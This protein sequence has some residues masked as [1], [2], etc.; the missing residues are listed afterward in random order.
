MS[1]VGFA[2]QALVALQ[3]LLPK[4]AFTA[5]CGLL[6]AVR[7]PPI[8][9]A[10]I[11]LFM[12]RYAISLTEADI[13]NPEGF[14]TFNDFFKRALK[15][16]ARPIAGTRLVSPADGRVSALGKI[17]KQRLIQAKGR[18][19]SL[20][21]LLADGE[22]RDTFATPFMDGDFCTIYLAPHNYHRVHMPLK[23]RLRHL[24]YVP[25]RLFSVNAA[26]A[27][28]V[29]HLFSKNERLIA[30]FETDFGILAYVMVG[31]LIVGGIDFLGEPIQRGGE[32]LDFMPKSG[33]VTLEK[34]AE[35]GAFRL[36]STVICLMEKTA[37][38]TPNVHA[39]SLIKV[40][41]PLF[42]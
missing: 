19:F 34:G 13:E 20:T 42:D 28:T 3:S 40:G 5:L 36:G 7:Y 26:T 39:G 1:H 41:E 30:L 4:K 11:R 2:A 14:A 8:K 15:K 24:R 6:A 35:L 9:N 38:F 37:L 17:Q 31:A 33:S 10:L 16:G 23:G 21:S 12:R 32:I 18:H 29:D 25:G 27:A 22:G